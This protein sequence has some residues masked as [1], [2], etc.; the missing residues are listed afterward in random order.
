MCFGDCEGMEYG[1]GDIEGPMSV[2]FHHPEDYTESI[3]GAETLDELFARTG[4]F[5]DEVALPQVN[6]GKDVLIVGHGAMNSSIVSRIREFPRADFWK[7]GIPNCKLI[8]L[9]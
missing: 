9:I 3:G 1:F 6:E 4:E 8:K 7:A 5:L 2:L